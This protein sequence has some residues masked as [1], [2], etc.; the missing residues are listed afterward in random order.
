MRL[1]RLG[2]LAAATMIPLAIAACA[3]DRVVLVPCQTAIV[4]PGAAALAVGDTLRFTASIVAD[5]GCDSQASVSRLRWTAANPSVALVDSLSGVVVGI[6]AGAVDV[7]AR[8][9]GT[10]EPLGSGHL[11]VFAPLFDRIVATR[12]RI[13]CTSACLSWRVNGPVGL[14]TLAPDGSDPRLLRDSLVWPDHPR[15]SPD[16]RTVAY[17]QS[18]GIY[19]MD[20]AGLAIRRLDTTLPTSWGPSWSPDGRWIAFSGFDPT[21]QTTQIFVIRPD[22]SGLRRVTSH[23]VGA[24][25]PSWSPD[26][27]TIAYTGADSTPAGVAMLVD[28]AGT[29]ARFVGEGVT[30]FR[31]RQPEWS[32]D[33][34]ALVFRSGSYL[35]R[36]TFATARYD[37]LAPYSG[38]RPASWAPDGSRIIAGAGEIEWM[39]PAR[40]TTYLAMNILLPL[41]PDSLYNMAPFYTPRRPAGRVR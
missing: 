2:L 26:G 36:F 27:T 40:P 18:P 34:G 12:F 5:A 28:A 11:V 21:N 22:G 37:T 29:N 38:N 32:L 16:G 3:A 39:D 8:R 19:L 25:E 13:S 23:P 24:S 30:G 10:Q 35:T 9:S 33:G 7:V 6:A 1:T 15:V 41:G 14:W 4:D 31:A 17:D 20:G